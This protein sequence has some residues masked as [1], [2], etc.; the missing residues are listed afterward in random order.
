ME[1]IILCDNVTNRL[2]YTLGFIFGDILGIRYKTSAEFTSGTASAW[3]CYGNDKIPG[4]YHIRN[5]GLLNETS[6]RDECKV[7]VNGYGEDCVLF[8]TE[9]SD[10]SFDIFSAVFFL[11][12]RYEEYYP[13][14][15]D[16]Y[17]RFPHTSSVA[18]KNGF[19]HYPM[20]NKWVMDLA[21]KIEKRFPSF[22]KPAINFSYKATY[23]IDIPWQYRNKGILRG[24]GGWLKS[25]GIGRIK[26]LCKISEDPFYSFDFLKKLHSKFGISPLYFWLVAEKRG[27][28]DKNVSPHKTEMKK[29][30][31]DHKDLS[32][33]LHPSWHSYGDASIVLKEKRILES[34]LGKSINASRQHYLRFRLPESFELLQSIG[35]SEEYSMGYGTIN[36]FR[37]ST[38][39][40]FNWFNLKNN[41]EA[42]LRIHPFCF[43]DA[44]SY[45]EQKQS[46]ETSFNEMMAYYKAC[47][48][49]GGTMITI[50]HNNFLGTGS[51][52]SGWAGMYEK[53][54]QEVHP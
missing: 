31:K 37:A 26:V 32:N 18:F 12:S 38:S 52:F 25:P 20:V 28:F 53:F 45:Y 2:D 48:K 22:K 29:L 9:D 42:K 17:Q 40:A 16:A 50:F 35:I 44:N 49:E 51:A 13:F 1:I 39:T 3:I 11:I 33:G 14:A 54:I 15:Q 10:H 7:H 41:E 34:I 23:D 27:E 19:L 30:I 8:P 24:L 6:F 4:T 5:T 21:S 46:P 43:M 47:K 36:G